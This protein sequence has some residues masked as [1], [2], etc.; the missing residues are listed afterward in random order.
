[1]IRD[2]HLLL[3]LQGG[4]ELSEHVGD[5]WMQFLAAVTECTLAANELQARRAGKVGTLTRLAKLTHSKDA[6]ARVQG[7]DVLALVQ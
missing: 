7:R 5:H 4:G 6:N 3:L 2:P 1:M